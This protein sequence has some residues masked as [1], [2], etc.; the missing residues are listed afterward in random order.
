MGALRALVTAAAVVVAVSLQSGPLAALAVAG[1]VPDLVLLLVVGVALVRGPQHAA[2]VG[3]LSGLV[4][5]LAPPADHTAGRWALALLVVGYLAG[6]VSQD[7]RHSA[8]AAIVTVAAAAF[9]GSSVFAL[10]GLLLGD[11]GVTVAHVLSVVPVEVLYDVALTPVVLPLV[12]A[13]S[14]RLEPGTDRWVRA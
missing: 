1:V 7:A 5:D 12:V 2:V 4:L 6:L 9:V 13:V 3:F 11:P 8:V 14:R 10:S